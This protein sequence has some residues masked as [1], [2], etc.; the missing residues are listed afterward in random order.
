MH[1]LIIEDQFLIAAQIEDVL[2]SMGYMSFDTVDTEVKAILAAEERCPDIITADQRITDGCGVEAVRAICIAR[3][4]PVVFVTSYPDEVRRLAPN[5][6][7]M[8]KPFGDRKLRDAVGQAVL[9]MNPT[10]PVASGDE[11][12][13]VGSGAM[14]R[15]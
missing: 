2:R 7:V 8:G 14:R 1:A 10:Q 3:S 4:I 13:D 11:L 6:I 15:L 5:A 9:R 12:R